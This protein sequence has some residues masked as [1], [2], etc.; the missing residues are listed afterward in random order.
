MRFLRFAIRHWSWYLQ[1]PMNR[2]IYH[3]FYSQNF[4]KKVLLMRMNDFIIMRRCS[5]CSAIIYDRIR[6]YYVLFDMK[7]ATTTKIANICVIDVNWLKNL[8]CLH[9]IWIYFWGLICE[10][11]PIN[12]VR[13]I[14]IWV[15]KTLKK[16][17]SVFAQSRDTMFEYLL[18]RKHFWKREEKKMR[19]WNVN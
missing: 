7:I 18:R 2:Q 11:L 17:R 14:K 6:E 4:T 12:H 19:R 13:L 5:K 15:Q 8:S 9:R 1:T 16:Y 10:Q 3:K